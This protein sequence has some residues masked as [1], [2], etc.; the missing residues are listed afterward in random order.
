MPI[1]KKL[2]AGRSFYFPFFRDLEGPFPVRRKGAVL[3]GSRI[4]FLTR[5]KRKVGGGE[6]RNAPYWLAT[7]KKQSRRKSREVITRGNPKKSRGL[8]SDET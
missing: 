1:K 2:F 7:R 8:S 3:T 4:R 6:G 5:R